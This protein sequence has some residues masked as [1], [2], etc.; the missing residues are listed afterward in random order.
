M[1]N[2]EQYTLAAFMNA[3]A[4]EKHINR[5]RNYYQH[6]RD[7]IL[8]TFLREPLGKYITISEEDSGVHFLMHVNTSMS[9]QEFLFKDKGERNPAGN[10]V[11]F[12]IMRNRKTADMKIRMS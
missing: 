10:V 4:F 7:L 9:E 1:S 11:F 8:S 12:F 6:K 3:G 2:F 5:L